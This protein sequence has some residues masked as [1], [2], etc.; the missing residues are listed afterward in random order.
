MHFTAKLAKTTTFYRPNLM[1]ELV[2]TK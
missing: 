1:H 2:Q